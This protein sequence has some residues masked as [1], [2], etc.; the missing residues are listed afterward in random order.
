MTQSFGIIKLLCKNT[1]MTT[2]KQTILR[3]GLI[4]SLI[5]ALSILFIPP[6]LPPKDA[7]LSPHPEI[8][9]RVVDGTG[10]KGRVA[11]ATVVIGNAD[12]SVF[13]TGKTDAKG[14]VTFQNPPVDAIVTAS[15]SYIDYA[16]GQISRQ[17]LEAYYNVNVTAL[18]IPL[19]TGRG[20]L[21]GKVNIDIVTGIPGVAICQIQYGGFRKEFQIKDGRA[22]A[23]LDIYREDFQN[24]G[25]LSFLL[26]GMDAEY[27]LLGY[28]T[29][30]DQN[31][32]DGMTI[33]ALV[34]RTDF[35][36]YNF[37]L[38]HVPET[39]RSYY[40]SV[41]FE[42][43]GIYS[44][45][46]RK[47]SSPL[48][49]DPIPSSVSVQTIPNAAESYCHLVELYTERKADGSGKSM[50]QMKK[51]QPAPTNQSFDFNQ[52]PVPPSNPKVTGSGTATPVF[53]W[54]GTHTAAD[55]MYIY[56]ITD[57]HRSTYGLHFPPSRRTVVFPKLPDTLASFR[58]AKLMFDDFQL[59]VDNYDFIEGWQDY[60]TKIDQFVSGT[61]SL[62]RKYHRETVQTHP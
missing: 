52:V 58:P 26:W 37:E 60:L 55:E 4:P 15:A 61:F 39:A 36:S 10:L 49:A 38:S 56:F 33:P 28:G 35:V 57:D 53:E 34:N 22:S 8:R 18:T 21:A 16:D 27:N 14:E 47:N 46:Y 1:F 32:T 40:R 29:V 44:Y 24:D 51:I 6:P 25:K 3:A 43:K 41:L 31:F 11:G 17:S 50:L 48:L 23:T 54:T 12:G 7:A 5:C 20:P 13:S 42:E 62:P 59:H 45:S 19:D 9:V 30:P 2:D